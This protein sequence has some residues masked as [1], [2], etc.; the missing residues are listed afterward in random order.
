MYVVN[1]TR[2]DHQRDQQ[3]NLVGLYIYMKLQLHLISTTTFGVMFDHTFSELANQ[4]IKHQGTHEVGCQPGDCIWS[5]QSSSG[6][7]VGIYGLTYS[8][9]HP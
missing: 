1:S 8:L 7:S 5:L 6:V 3:A 9:Y 4:Q 2:T